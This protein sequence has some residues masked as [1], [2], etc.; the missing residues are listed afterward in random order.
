RCPLNDR[1]PPESGSP[2]AVLLC[3]KR[4]NRLASGPS[5]NSLL[6]L[7]GQGAGVPYCCGI[8]EEAAVGETLR[9]GSHTQLFIWSAGHISVWFANRVD[10]LVCMPLTERRSAL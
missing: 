8:E 10:G 7:F 3:R 4:A 1:S 6:P 9:R 2:S 5:L